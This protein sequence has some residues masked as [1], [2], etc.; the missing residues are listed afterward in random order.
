[1]LSL[2]FSLFFGLSLSWRSI[3]LLSGVLFIILQYSIIPIPFKKNAP[4]YLKEI[5]FIKTFILIFSWLIITLFLPIIESRWWDSN[6]FIGL[7]CSWI[8]WFLINA[9]LFD[10]RD[11]DIDKTTKTITIPI[12]FGKN[13]THLL[14][15]GIGIFHVTIWLVFESLFHG[16]PAAPILVPTCLMLCLNTI[17]SFSGKTLLKY[18]PLVDFVFCVPLIIY[19]LFP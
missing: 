3:L 15:Y 10:I 5:P 12:L 17:F 2:G 13:K 9:L 16:I 19:L 7:S 1:M 14:I 11:Y 4:I 6:L 8:A 18:Y